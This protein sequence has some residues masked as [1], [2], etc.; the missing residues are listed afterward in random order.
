[1]NRKPNLSGQHLDPD[2]W[3]GCPDIND[4]DAFGARVHGD[5]MLPE[6]KE[7]DIVIFSPAAAVREGNDCFV[8]FVDGH[9]TFKR[10]WFLEHKTIVRLQPLNT[11]YRPQD[12]PVVEIETI[13]RA[14]FKYT[15]TGDPPE[16]RDQ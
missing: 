15:R 10:V 5:A 7:G 12:V 13:T 16:A 3:V 8:R 14:V 1:M 6:Y 4:P 11:R 9:T 2:N